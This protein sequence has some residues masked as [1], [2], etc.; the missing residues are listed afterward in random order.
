[1]SPSPAGL[2]L[3]ASRSILSR[4]DSPLWDDAP[5]RRRGVTDHAG[6]G[7]QIGEWVLEGVARWTDFLVA[8]AGATS[9][10]AGLVFVALSINLARILE[11]PGVPARAGETI[12]ILA[13][14]L[15]GSLIALIPNLEPARL[16]LAF[17]VL[18]LPTWGIPTAVQIRALRLHRYY[19]LRLAWY[20][21]A[22]HQIA[23]IPL[24]L[25]GLSLNGYL[26]GGLMWFAA[27]L[28]AFLIV[29]LFSAWVLLVEILR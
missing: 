5:A 10:L 8:G 11:L 15:I 16:G 28:V 12:L 18:W 26:P 9:A 7:T 3:S 25:A 24:L 23:T 27:A 14:G 6:T 17:M 29:S 2:A 4:I 21:F 1:M 13:S 22:L 19:R 20:R